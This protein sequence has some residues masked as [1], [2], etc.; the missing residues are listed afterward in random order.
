VQELPR[1]REQSGK[2]AARAMDCPKEI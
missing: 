1:I 2:R